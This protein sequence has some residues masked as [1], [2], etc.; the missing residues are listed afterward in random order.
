MASVLVDGYASSHKMKQRGVSNPLVRNVGG[1]TVVEGLRFGFVARFVS[2]GPGIQ[3]QK[4][5]AFTAV[6]F[7]STLRSF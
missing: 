3:L 5:P 6:L 7:G 4:S 2:D 1:V